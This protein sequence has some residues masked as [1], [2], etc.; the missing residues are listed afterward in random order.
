MAGK[1]ADLVREFRWGRMDE[2]ARREARRAVEF[3][4]NRE[5]TAA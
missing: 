5:E 2:L 4:V 3:E 1:L